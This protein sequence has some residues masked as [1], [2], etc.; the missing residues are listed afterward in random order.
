MTRAYVNYIVTTPDCIALLFAPLRK[1]VSLR[2]REI[3][4]LRKEVSREGAKK[5]E[6]RKDR[7]SGCRL[8]AELLILQ[9]HFRVPGLK[10]NQPYF[11]QLPIGGQKVFNRS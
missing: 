10:E 6:R 2:L 5:I 8:I 1:V 9:K 7:T 11:F 3:T 4:K